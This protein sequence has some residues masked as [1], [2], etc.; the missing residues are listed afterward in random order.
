MVL[1]VPL[2]VTAPH[3]QKLRKYSLIDNADR[4][5]R[6]KNARAGLRHGS[7]DDPNELAVFACDFSAIVAEPIVRPA[8]GVLDR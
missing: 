6:V 4:Y 2:A 1:V 3:W 5:L 7:A 8:W